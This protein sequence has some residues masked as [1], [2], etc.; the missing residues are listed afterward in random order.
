MRKYWYILGL[1]LLVMA[2]KKQDKF[3]KSAMLSNIGEVVVLPSLSSFEQQASSLEQSLN[4]FVNDPTINNLEAAQTQWLQTAQAWSLAKNYMFGIAKDRYLHLSLGKNPVN[5]TPI[6]DLIT[7]TDAIDANSVKGQ[8]S[9]TKGVFAIE[10]LLYGENLS[11]TDVINWYTTD[12]LSTRRKAYL[13]GL[14]ERLHIVAENWDKIWKTSDENYITIFGSATS[15]DLQGSI[16]LLSNAMINL[17]NE[18]ARLNLGQP[19]GKESVDGSVQSNKLESRY[20]NQGV[21][22]LIKKLEGMRLVFTG[23]GGAGFNEYL[24]HLSGEETLGNDI[25]VKI[26]AIKVLLEGMNSSMKEALTSS[27]K[28]TLEQAYTET[29][30]LLVYL[31]TDMATLFN[32]TVLPSDSDGD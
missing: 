30:A 21:Q 25:L 2:C 12:S 15:D 7:G 32:I 19:L 24:N 28:A 17:C 4:T 18:M 9:Y 11:S 20:A 3:D 29:K 31:N 16:S 14:G 26:D 23:S 1:S 8:S 6:E 5:P 10:Y 13:V 27:E 22:L